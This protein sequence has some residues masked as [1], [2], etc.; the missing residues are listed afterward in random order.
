MVI[1]EIPQ[2]RVI[3]P[4]IAVGHL[5]G[6]WVGIAML[7]GALIGWGWGVP[8]YAAIHAA[9]AASAGTAGVAQLAQET[10]SHQ[11]RFVGAGTILVAALWTLAK[12]VKP[13]YGGL[14]SAMAASR[15]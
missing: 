1:A 13:V 10:W 3:D 4:R 7:V 14:L 9:S 5:V 2:R 15:E 6:L 12:L 11:V 8:Y